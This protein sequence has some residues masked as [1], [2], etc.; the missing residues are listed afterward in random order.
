[1][2]VKLFTN[3]LLGCEEGVAHWMFENSFIFPQEIL[4][5]NQIIIKM[6]PIEQRARELKQEREMTR[7]LVALNQIEREKEFED[8]YK[9]LMEKCK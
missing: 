4:P 1:M 3:F 8:K 7:H 5:H 9:R 6:K 2:F